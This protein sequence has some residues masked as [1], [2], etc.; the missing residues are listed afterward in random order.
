MAIVRQ[1][2]SYISY[3]IMQDIVVYIAAIITYKLVLTPHTSLVSYNALGSSIM[4][5]MLG[6][7]ST[8]LWP[9]IPMVGEGSSPHQ[10]WGILA[11]WAGWPWWR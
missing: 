6:L 3:I 11:S 7:T 4:R 9:Q 5:I 10:G 2:I 8:L 1:D